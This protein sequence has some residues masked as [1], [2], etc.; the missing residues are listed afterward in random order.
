MLNLAIIVSSRKPLTKWY[1]IYVVRFL[2]IKCNSGPE[3]S[4]IFSNGH[5]CLNVLGPKC[6]TSEVS[7]HR[8]LSRLLPT[9]M[10]INNLLNNNLRIDST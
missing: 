2:V 9:I 4:Q 3:V 5:Q 8:S 6:L 1:K 7:V 10:L